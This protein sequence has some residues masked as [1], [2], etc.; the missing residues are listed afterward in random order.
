[1]P[2]DVEEANICSVTGLLANETCPA[3]TDLILKKNATRKCSMT[4]AYT[5]TEGSETTGDPPPGSIGF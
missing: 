5:P 2:F 4:H 1:M 3:Y